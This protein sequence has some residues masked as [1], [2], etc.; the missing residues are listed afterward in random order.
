M[1]TNCVLNEPCGMS[2]VS[3]VIITIHSSAEA[4]PLFIIQVAIFFIILVI[5]NQDFKG[6]SLIIIIL[7]KISVYVHIFNQ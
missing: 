5:R 4:F 1:I 6:I 7:I 2:R 3:K